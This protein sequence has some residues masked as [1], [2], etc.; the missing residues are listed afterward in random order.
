MTTDHNID[1]IFFPGF[2]ISETLIENWPIQKQL[3]ILP[4][5]QIDQIWNNHKQKLTK[6]FIIIALSLGVDMMFKTNAYN[7]PNCKKVYCF[8]ARPTYPKHEIKLVK[9]FIINDYINYLKQFYNNCFISRK[10]NSWSLY[11]QKQ[12]NTL[13]KTQLLNELQLVSQIQIPELRSLKHSKL[14]FIHG[15][16]DKIAP[17]K[18]IQS[19]IDTSQ[20]TILKDCGHIECFYTY[21]ELNKLE[22]LIPDY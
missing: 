4:S 5:K 11:E 21:L 6:P 13:T 14:Q 8:S 9:N 3:V 10:P 1:I 15:E 17:L 22:D 2:S 12:L 16:K 20:L 18:E 19:I 7:H